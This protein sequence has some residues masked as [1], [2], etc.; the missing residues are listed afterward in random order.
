LPDQP[1]EILR[2]LIDHDVLPR[3]FIR[4]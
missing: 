2:L 4:A 3:E 1:A